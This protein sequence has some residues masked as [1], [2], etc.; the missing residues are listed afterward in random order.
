MGLKDRIA[1]VAEDLNLTEKVFVSVGVDR[2]RVHPA[3]GT[4]LIEVLGASGETL[5]L[6]TI[7]ATEPAPR[8]PWHVAGKPTTYV[9]VGTTGHSHQA[10]ACVLDEIPF[11]LPDHILAKVDLGAT[12]FNIWWS[13][14]E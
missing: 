10:F 4:I 12:S 8:G 3:K 2:K 6:D 11:Q 1:S 9:C 14:E 7:K 5:I 13:C